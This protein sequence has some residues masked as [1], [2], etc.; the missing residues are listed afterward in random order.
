VLNGFGKRSDAAKSGSSTN[1]GK[2]KE[3]RNV[4]R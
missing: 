3:A 4:N 2:T 1:K